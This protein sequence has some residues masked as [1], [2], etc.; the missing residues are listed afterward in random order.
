MNEKD[1]QRFWAKVDKSGDC[2]EWT[3]SRRNGYGQMGLDGR[4]EYAHRISYQMVNGAIPPGLV[5]RHSC[6]NRGCVN[7]AHLEIGTLE[8]NNQDA[9]DR[10]RHA[11]ASKTA[12]YGSDNGR[13]KLTDSQ[14]AEIRSLYIKGQRGYGSKVLAEKFGVGSAHILRIVRG[15]N[16]VQS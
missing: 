16:R 7:P 6:D 2:W 1:A 9:I 3:A 13:A 10:N 14:V 8:E 5:V 15:Q 4:V 12:H 11:P